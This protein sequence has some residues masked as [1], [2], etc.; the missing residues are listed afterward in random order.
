MFGCDAKIGLSTSS[1]PHGL[2]CSLESEED[3]VEHLNRAEEEGNDLRAPGHLDQ[4]DTQDDGLEI[5]I[6]TV[7]EKSCFVKVKCSMCSKSVHEMCSKANADLV[8][9]HL[10]SNEEVISEERRNASESE[11]RQANR[12]RN[13]SERILTEVEVEKNIFIPIPM[14]DRGKGDPRNLLAVILSR[15]EHGYKLGTKSGVLHGLYT[16]NQFELS[17]NNFLAKDTVQLETEIS[18]RQAVSDASICDGQGFTKCGCSASGKSRCNTK[19]CLFKKM[20]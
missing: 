1:L 17:D 15:E 2:L 18:L 14:V 3:L 6:C 11:R 16:R 20:D 10:C 13:L 12:M 7:C 19:R 9:C 4:P 8:V 5:E